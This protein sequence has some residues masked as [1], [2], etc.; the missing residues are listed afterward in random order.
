M[1][2]LERSP[3]QTH[4]RYSTTVFASSRIETRRSGWSFRSRRE[5]PLPPDLEKHHASLIS[6]SHIP[7][8]HLPCGC[9]GEACADAVDTPTST[10]VLPCC[11]EGENEKSSCCNNKANSEGGCQNNLK[12]ESSRCCGEKKLDGGCRGSGESGVSCCGSGDD[13]CC[14]GGESSCG[15]QEDDKGNVDHD[16]GELTITVCG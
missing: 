5:R 2:V 4:A 8:S 12:A 9:S 6:M 16:D 7:T 13:Q 10:E 3:M 1:S 15:E 11:S 14:D